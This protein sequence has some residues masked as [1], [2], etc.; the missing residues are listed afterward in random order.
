MTEAEQAGAAIDWPAVERVLSGVD[1]VANALGVTLGPKGRTVEIGLPD[2]MIRTT[3]RGVYVAATLDPD[4]G[5]E[6]L[7]A[8]I[9]KDIVNKTDRVSGDGTTTAAILVQSV[10]RDSVKAIKDGVDPI[11]LQAGIESAL[12]AV[13]HELKMRSQK[14]PTATQLV[15][16]GRVAAGGDPE[17]GEIVGTA[18]R[19]VENPNLIVIE[20]MTSPGLAVGMV[21]GMRIRGGYSSAGFVIGRNVMETDLKDPSILFV[22]KRIPSIWSL[23]PLLRQL[24]SSAR[25]SKGLVI[26]TNDLDMEAIARLTESRLAP[27]LNIAVVK[28]PGTGEV[29]R[30]LLHQMAFLTGGRVIAGDRATLHHDISAQMLG[31]AKEVRFR[32]DSTMIIGGSA[33]L[34]ISAHELRKHFGVHGALGG[35]LDNFIFDVATIRVG[36]NSETDLVERKSRIEAAVRAVVAAA[37]E[38]VVAG[39][40]VAFV[41]AHGVLD[42]LTHANSSQ[43]VGADIVK[44]ALGKPLKQLLTNAGVAAGPI[45]DSLLERRNARLGYDVDTSSYTDMIDAGIIDPAKVVRSA[46]EDAASLTLALVADPGKFSISLARGSRDRSLTTPRREAE[47]ETQTP[48]PPALADG[49]QSVTFAETADSRRSADSGPSPAAS[50]PPAQRY[51]VGKFPEQVKPGDVNTLT[52]QIAQLV[53]AGRATPIADLVIPEGGLLLDIVVQADSFEFLGPRHA[54]LRVPPVG[55]SNLVGF[56]LR[57]PEDGNGEARTIRISAFNGGTCVGGLELQVVVNLASP[58]GPTTQEEKSVVGDITGGDTD[59]TLLVS[60]IKDKKETIGYDLTW[61]G[62]GGSCAPR[63]MPISKS[64]AEQL[65]KGLIAEIQEIALGAYQTEPAT[66]SRKLKA[67]GII[68]WQQLIPSDLQKR[69]IDHHEGI[70]RLS[71]CSAGDPIPWEMLFPFDTTPSFDKGFL[72][73]QVEVSR[74]R[75]GSLPPTHIPLRRADFVLPGEDLPNANEEINELRRL[76]RTEDS[77]DKD[78]ILEASQLFALFEKPS[79]NVLHFACHNGLDGQG[80][81]ILIHEVP[82]KPNDFALYQKKVL[83]GDAFVFMNACH[84]AASQPKYT[85]IGG[86]ANCFLDTGV[87]AFIGTAWEVR[88]ETAQTFAQALYRELLNDRSFGE[89]LNAARKAV[90]DGAPGD[91]TWLAYSF[92]GNTTTRMKATNSDSHSG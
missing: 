27:G 31:R 66:A 12:R 92:Y 55:N 42:K 29:R 47:I 34:S 59:V 32:P 61:L 48:V 85:A 84:T 7:G 71:I 11:D 64:E 81:R 49:S 46:L 63:P 54:S 18:L 16:V 1:L 51:L 86:W 39:G 87:G 62:V 23:M 14:R 91:P 58:V 30:A 17:I 4:D 19:S 22:E 78:T 37:E 69:F 70:K 36:Y 15:Q 50:Q 73:E 6:R 60:P 56:E 57:A 90:K 28:T 24:S 45:M 65:I 5:M 40:G 76:L 26:V 10:L 74:W 89:A 83:K 38:G 13:S 75:W 41:H 52:A 67:R 72:V 79:V 2:G 44:S 8:Q 33:E 3:K 35:R 43:Q 88:D 20:G 25:L 80:E 53:R 21:P 68:L 82:V 9:L 77:T